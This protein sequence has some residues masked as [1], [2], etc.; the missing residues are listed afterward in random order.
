[1]ED[2]TLIELMPT[3]LDTLPPIAEGGP[4]WPAVSS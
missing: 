2:A 3:I 4:V 1:M